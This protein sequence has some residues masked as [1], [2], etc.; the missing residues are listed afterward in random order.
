M[1]ALLLTALP[2]LASAVW[3]IGPIGRD[4][5]PSTFWPL[6]AEIYPVGFW[7][8]V[9]VCVCARGVCGGRGAMRVPR[10]VAL[11]AAAHVCVCLVNGP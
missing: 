1:R 5:G 11:P 8:D 6:P 4:V 3:N 9:K 10:R 2:A 7:D